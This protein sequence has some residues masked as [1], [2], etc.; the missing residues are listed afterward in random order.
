MAPDDKLNLTE[1][2]KRYRLNEAALR[3]L[4]EREDLTPETELTRERFKELIKEPD[5]QES[6]V[7]AS[8]APIK[9]AVKEEPVTEERRKELSKLAAEKGVTRPRVAALKVY[10]GWEDSTKITEADLDAAVEK[11]L[12]GKE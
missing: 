8:T 7:E 5:A 1:W 12:K 9:E 3:A 4:C 10:T 6:G 2:A 11:Y